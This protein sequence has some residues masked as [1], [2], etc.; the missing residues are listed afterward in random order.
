VNKS[1]KV[2]LTISDKSEAAR[3]SLQAKEAE[4]RIERERLRDLRAQRDTRTSA[5]VLRR[6]EA[7]RSALKRKPL[8]VAETNRALRQ[9]VSRIVL[10]P[11]RATLTF[12]WQHAE[13]LTQEVQFY[14]RR[15]AAAISGPPEL[16]HRH[17]SLNQLK[18]S[19]GVAE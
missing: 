4:L 3:V 12:H 1:A 13:Q 14:T 8:N 7:V 15:A 18:D 16:G 10:D 19:K 2:V 11:E 5:N 6:L 9:A 17:V